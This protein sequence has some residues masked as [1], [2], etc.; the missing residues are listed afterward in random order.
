M[1]L[2]TTI[3][4]LIALL[5]ACTVGAVEPRDPDQ[6]PFA[7]TSIWNM[8]IGAGAHYVA[9]GIKRAEQWGLVADEDIVIMTPQAPLVPVFESN[10]GWSS[11]QAGSRCLPT[12]KKL[13]DLP[14]PDSFVLPHPAD[15]TPNFA[16]GVLMPDGHTVRNLQPL[17]RCQ[18][19]G[20]AT[21]LV[22]FPSSDLYGDGIVGA[23]GGSG[24]SSI[25]GTLRLGELQPGRRL[26]H[27]LKVVIYGKKY[28]AYRQ[29]N[30]PGYRFPALR[31]DSYAKDTYGGVVPELEMGALLALKPTFNLGALKTEPA[32]IL[33]Q[34][35]MDYGAY[36]V[37]DTAWDTYGFAVE[38]SPN[39]MFQAEFKQT[40]G[41]NF[42]TPAVERNPWVQD[43]VTIFTSLHVIANNRA[44]AI[45]GGGKLRQPLAP[46]FRSQ[47]SYSQRRG[48]IQR[49][50]GR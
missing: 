14:I 27:A 39:G 7:S 17:T 21:A 12:G 15:S 9:A 11:R 24:L 22:E 42:D 46:E 36:V 20:A 40:W 28:I 5:L 16:A 4:C 48:A 37:D 8:P 19:K 47:Q 49:L 44:D 45:G 31:A 10:V 18:V 32:K 13:G 41:F 34:A 35:L 23:H 29:D 43:M 1:R 26:R 6:W 3:A 25:G 38:R 50:R 2:L 30:T 33:A